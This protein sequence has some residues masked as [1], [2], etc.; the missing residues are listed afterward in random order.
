[1]SNSK[2]IWQ[3]IIKDAQ[4]RGCFFDANDDKDL[5]N[6]IIKAIIENDDA[7]NLSKMDSM[8]ISRPR[9]QVLTIRQ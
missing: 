3:K 7:E 6:A 9:F 8:H 4:D 1:M 5:S 2:S